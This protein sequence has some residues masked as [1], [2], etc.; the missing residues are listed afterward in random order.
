MDLFVCV[1]V[2]GQSVFSRS[3][4]INLC[5]YGWKRGVNIGPLLYYFTS[6]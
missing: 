1:C 5:R 2:R 3:T 4:G 6:G